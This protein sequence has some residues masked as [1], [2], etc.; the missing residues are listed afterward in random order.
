M[1]LT[2][3]LLALGMGVVAFGILHLIGISIILAYPFLTLRLTNL[4]LGT[5]IFPRRPVH[6]GP[7]PRLGRASGSCLSAS[8]QRA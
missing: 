6:P 5:L 4:V 8:Y 3:V 1:V 7:G 2:V